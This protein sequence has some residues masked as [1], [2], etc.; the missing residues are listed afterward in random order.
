MTA[1]RALVEPGGSHRAISTGWQEV[2][3]EVREASDWLLCET[4]NQDVP[5]TV[6]SDH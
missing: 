2:L 5:S 3:L 6:L 4:G 1:G